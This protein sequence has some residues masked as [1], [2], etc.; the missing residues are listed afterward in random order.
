MVKSYRVNDQIHQY[1]IDY[2]IASFAW[3]KNVK[4]W[5]ILC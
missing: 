1:E 2:W 5:V 4:I 3:K